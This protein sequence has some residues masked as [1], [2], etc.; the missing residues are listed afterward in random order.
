MVTTDRVYNIPLRQ[1]FQKAPKYKRAKKAVSAIKEFLV[2]HMKSDN[3]K[4]G[5]SIN[6]KVW[7]NGIKN[8]PHHVKVSVTKDDKGEVKAELFGIEVK[9]K[10]T[11]KKVSKETKKSDDKKEDIV[12]V[13][14]KSEK[15]KAEVKDVK[16]ETKPSK[17]SDDKKSE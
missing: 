6:L 2:K 4:I 13:K 5:T 10:E 15:P 16:K 12:E 17:K 11:V 7:E 14:E 8:P 9:K 3:I 1:E